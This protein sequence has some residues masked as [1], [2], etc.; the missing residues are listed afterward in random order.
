[1]KYIVVLES[2]SRQIALATIF[3]VVIFIF[4]LIL[5]FPIDKFLLVFFQCT[6]LALG[7][8][9]VGF[10]GATYV[11]LIYGVLTAFARPTTG[12][13]IFIFAILYGVLVDGLIRV[14]GSLDN[15]QDINLYSLITVLAISSSMVGVISYLVTVYLLHIMPFNSMIFLSTL[16]TGLITG[17]IAAYLVKFILKRINFT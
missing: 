1:M 3:G 12:L 9:L 5:P 7:S 6:L 2:R 14:V 13:S 15:P 10:G 8:L 16:V 4:K 11:S 17:I